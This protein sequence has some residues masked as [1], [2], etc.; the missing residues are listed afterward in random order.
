MQR[1]LQFKTP[2]THF[3]EALPLGNGRLGAMFYGGVE[4][5]RIHLNE[6]SL[7]SGSA[8]APIPSN[9]L[10]SLNEIRGLLFEGKLREAHDLTVDS[11]AGR[12]NEA[13]QPVG[14]LLI[15]IVSACGKPE[16]YSRRL[17][18]DSATGFTEFT[19]DGVCHSRELL[20]SHPSQCLLLKWSVNKPAALNCRIGM[21][22]PLHHR[23]QVKDSLL[24][25]EG[26]APFHVGWFR[27]KPGEKIIYDDR[28]GHRGMTF[29]SGIRVVAPGALISTTDEG[30]LVEGATELFLFGDTRTGITSADPSSAVLQTLLTAA[31]TD[32]QRLKQLHLVDYRT[33]FHRVRLDLGRSS[34]GLRNHSLF[35]RLNLRSKGSTDPELEALLFDYGRYLLIS[36]SRPGSQPANLQGIWNKDV[37]PPWWSN[38]TLNINTEMNYWP[39]EPCDMPEVHEPLFDYVERLKV[40]GENVAGELYGCRGWTAHHQ[41]DYWCSAT[42][43]GLTPGSRNDSASRYAFWPM[44][45]AWLS[46]HF[47][48]HVLFT[49]DLKFLRDRAWPVMEGAALFLL[50]FLVEHPDG[51]LTTAPS[52]SPE[53]SFRFGDDFRAAIATGSTMDLSI[54]RD[55]FGNCLEASDRLDGVDPLFLTQLKDALDRLPPIAITSSGRIPEW[56]RDYTEWEPHHRHVSH[57]YGLHPASEFTPERTPELAAA[58]RKTLE[59]RTDEGTGWALAWKINFWARLH[60]GERAHRLIGKFFNPVP[61]NQV[62]L[63]YPG[64][65][66][67]NLLC[68]HPPFQIDGN[69]GYTAGVVEMLLQSHLR[70]STSGDYEIQLL[71]ALP[72]AWPEGEATGLRARGN[73]GIDLKWFNGQLTEVILTPAEKRPVTVHYGKLSRI[74]TAPDAGRPVRLD[75]MLNIFS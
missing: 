4:S 67:P 22:S 35:E 26:E 23:L 5:E 66:Y 21:T 63:E 15:D 69:F 25:L 8:S 55:L 27:V 29:V 37:Q 57:L 75:A 70:G 11:M 7:W 36:S 46:R 10:S 32:W 34:E 19:L 14:D 65:L 20:V 58:A 18:L 53:N 6:D 56:D 2:A 54:I 51:H 49:G 31:A 17:D 40:E 44:G 62:S 1:L 12:F 3:N 45:G 71:P 16:G 42:P 33:L 13:Y 61:A 9:G 52:T 74:I 50:D 47:W 72:E 24:I 30:L 43:V 68:A 38:F 48:D 60:D 59:V 28:P 64:G 39:A 73:M 41:T